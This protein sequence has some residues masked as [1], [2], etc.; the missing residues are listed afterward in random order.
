VVLMFGGVALIWLVATMAESAGTMA[1]LLKVTGLVKGRSK[2]AP[3]IS[4][5]ASASEYA[6]P[7]TSPAP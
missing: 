1:E 6:E 4:A 2:I 5:P 3:V 7:G